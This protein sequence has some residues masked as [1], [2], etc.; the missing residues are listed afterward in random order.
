MTFVSGLAAFLLHAASFWIIVH[1][2]GELNGAVRF[3]CL[4]HEICYARENK[5]ILPDH[6]VVYRTGGYDGQFY[7]YAA[8]RIAGEHTVLDSDAFRMARI[9]FPLLLSPFTA[10]G[11]GAVVVAMAVIPF[12][13]HLLAV[14]ALERGK[15]L[16]AVNPFSLLSASLML[17]DGLAFS[18]AVVALHAMRRDRVLPAFAAA[19]AA[20]LCKE[21]ALVLPAAAGI[22]FLVSPPRR[23]SAYLAAAL[24]AVPLFLW[25]GIS[26]FSPLFA[27]TRG[28]GSGLLEYLQSPD[29]IFSGRGILAVFLAVI[30]VKG[31]LSLRHGVTLYGISFLAAATAALLASSEYWDNYA[32]IA[33][34]FFP[35]VLGMLSRPSWRG[36]LFFFAWS[37]FFVYKEGRSA[38]VLTEL[39]FLVLPPQ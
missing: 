39:S 38:P 19:S 6:P 35:A 29:A 34:L 36:G 27:V 20:C 30:T 32:N 3:G 13:F 10:A 5:S 37:L 28:A 11:P 23:R 14:S 31:L 24:G 15:F 25:W 7:Y 4:N 9:G 17:S 8:Y 16:F 22:L 26:G 18:L 21:T 2:T 1:K 12:L 33:R